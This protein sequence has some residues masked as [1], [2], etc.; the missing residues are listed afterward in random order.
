MKLSEDEYIPGG[1][2]S[3]DQELEEELLNDFADEFDEQT[4][5]RNQHVSSIHSIDHLMNTTRSPIELWQR[6]RILIAL[7]LYQVNIIGFHDLLFKS[8][9]IDSN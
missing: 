5:R 4:I 3:L 2:A 8:E 7:H 6:A 9:K 1:F